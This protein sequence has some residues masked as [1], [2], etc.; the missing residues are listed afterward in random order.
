MEIDY[1]AVEDMG[2]AVEYAKVTRRRSWSG[3]GHN[4]LTNR[5]PAVDTHMAALLPMEVCK[6]DAQLEQLLASVEDMGALEVVVCWIPSSPSYLAHT[7][8]LVIA[9]PLDPAQIR[10]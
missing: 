7:L 10:P 3:L 9:P 4:V 5:P 6:T 2:E 8:Q 1:D